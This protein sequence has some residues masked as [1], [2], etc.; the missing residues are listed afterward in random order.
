MWSDWKHH[1]A[2]KILVSITPNRAFNFISKARDG[3]TS[4]VHLTRESEFYNILEPYDAVMV[5]PG[6]SI[7]E[8]LCQGKVDKISS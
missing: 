4:D 7:A 3:Y 8:D 1:N 2:T 5:D 6:F